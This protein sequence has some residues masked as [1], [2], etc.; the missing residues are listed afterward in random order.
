MNPSRSGANVRTKRTTTPAEY[1][2]PQTGP[3]TSVNSQQIFHSGAN[4]T[5]ANARINGP[6]GNGNSNNNS[7]NN[8]GNSNSNSNNNSNSNSNNNGN[9]S[10]SLDIINPPAGSKLTVGNAVALITLRLSR[11]ESFMNQYNLEDQSD[12]VMR[13]AL[14]RIS[15]LEQ[16]MQSQSQSQSQS[17]HTSSQTATAT[18]K[19]SE[20][21]QLVLSRLD[22]LEKNT[23][24]HTENFLVMSEG[25][26][27]LE[28]SLEAFSEVED[29]VDTQPN[30]RFDDSS[31]S[32]LKLE[33]NSLSEELK[34]TKN[35][36]LKLQSFTMETNAKLVN[37]IF[38][39]GD[40][41]DIQEFDNGQDEFNRYM[42]SGTFD[43]EDYADGVIGLNVGLINEDESSVEDESE[44]DED[45]KPKYS[46][47]N[48]NAISVNFKEMI[49]QELLGSGC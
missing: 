36:L 38:S 44:V 12:E 31:L 15:S 34:E 1:A 10:K 6:N 48:S 30:S 19:S 24:T 26:K 13:T 22:E 8:N 41:F 4:T 35:L 45:D 7:N 20:I 27:S 18:V 43:A 49:N 28:Q 16:K 33:F 23:T 11:L 14:A 47:G 5:G 32:S 3:V 39:Q 40:H 2:R 9:N 21:S 25:L 37:T 46:D 17:H 29:A 42:C